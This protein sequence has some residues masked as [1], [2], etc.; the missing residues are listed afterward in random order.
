MTLAND[1]ARRLKAEL[2]RV[3]DGKRRMRIVADEIITACRTDRAVADRLADEE[4][5]AWLADAGDYTGARRDKSYLLLLAGVGM[6]VGLRGDREK[7]QHLIF[8]EVQDI[9]PAEWLILNTLLGRGGRWS[10]FGDMNQRR[11]DSTSP[12][13]EHLLHEVLELDRSDGTELGHEVLAVGYRSTRQILRYAGRLLPRG[14]AAPAA[15]RDGP[16]PTVRRVG[17]KQLIRAA[18]EAAEQLADE[19][20][21]G[22]TAVIAWDN[23]KLNEV[24]T[25]CLKAGWRQVA[26]D[27]WTLHHPPT[28]SRGR[29]R[30]ARPVFA[31]GLEFDAVV[32]AEPDDFQ[33]NLGRH[34]SLYTALTRANQ[35]LTVVHTKALPKE[36]K[37]R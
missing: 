37:T 11:A 21:A 9:R 12:T 8:D 4:H 18:H 14:Q 13:W 36:L 27:P 1:T 30:L 19:F 16:E 7:H 29:L 17:P 23:N 33:K 10:L 15:L 26:G 3:P 34:G 32:V 24:Q 6:A 20:P 2:A 5:R 28:R 25:L 22:T 31:R 35:K